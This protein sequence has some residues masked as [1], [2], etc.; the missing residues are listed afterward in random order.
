MVP[1]L[2]CSVFHLFWIGTKIKQHTPAKD[3]VHHLFA[4]RVC[5]Q[6][7]LLTECGSIFSQ[8]RCNDSCQAPEH[9]HVMK[10]LSAVSTDRSALRH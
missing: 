5:V 4:L 8:T 10:Q 2:K 1:A 7:K 3:K 6:M 9:V